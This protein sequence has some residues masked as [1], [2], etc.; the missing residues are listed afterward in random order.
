MLFKDTQRS[1]Y[2][3]DIQSWRIETDVVEGYK[4]GTDFHTGFKQRTMKGEIGRLAQVAN[5]YI[6]SC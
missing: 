5:N 1:D 4:D 6:Y 2:E 3:N